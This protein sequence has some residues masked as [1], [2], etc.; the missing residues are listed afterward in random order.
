MNPS[1]E[2]VL[3]DALHLTPVERAELIRKLS[4]GSMRK[5]EPGALRK[6]FGTINS[7]DERSCD[8]DK[9]DADLAR[10]YA[11]NHEFEN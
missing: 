2:T 4:S 10:A 5:K 7:G 1:V 9:I 8:N 3:R 6:H 11:D